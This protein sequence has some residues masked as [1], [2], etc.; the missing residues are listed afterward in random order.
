M[1]ETRLKVVLALLLVVLA[2]LG[3]RAAQLQ[4]V[5]AG[6]WRQKADEA[7]RRSRLTDTIRGTVYDVKGRVL[8]IDAGCFDACI[9][10]RAIVPDP[11]PIWVRNQAAA[12]I[13][14]QYGAAWAGMD[15]ADKR[16]IRTEM[17]QGV[18]R[19]IKLMWEML[20][21]LPGQTPQSIA[22]T[23]AAI[24]NKVEMRKRNVWYRS[25]EK[26]LKEHEK[27]GPAPWYERWVRGEDGDVPQLE[28][29]EVTVGEEISTH[30]VIPAV[31]TDVQNLLAKDLSKYPGLVIR[32]GIHRQYPYGNTG[33]HLMG[34]LARVDRS[35]IDADPFVGHDD[36][37]RYLPSDMIGRGG[38]EGLGE[39]I[40]RGRRG[41]ITRDIAS[42]QIIE[43][44]SP[45]PGG[46]L[47]T[48]IDIE[49]QR[50]I[51]ALFERYSPED[52]W[53][54]AAPGAAV[55]I[56]VRTGEVRAL[57][58][59]PTFDPNTIDDTYAS[60]ARD[61]I[62]QPLLNRATMAQYEPGS[63]VKP[64]IGL[65]AITQGLADIH[66]TVHC[67]GY[68]RLDGRQYG[69]GRCWTTSI[70]GGSTHQQIPWDDPHPT[71][72]LRYEEAIQR[73][74]NIYF[75]TMGHR[76]GVAG[77]SRWLEAFGL[78]HRTGIGIP[79]TDGVVPGDFKLPSYLQHSTA[80]FASIGQGK[81]NATPLQMANVAATI[82][83]DGVWMR[84]RLVG[85]EVDSLLGPIER[86][87]PDVL[88]LGLDPAAVRIA[89]MG[90]DEV[91]N[92]RAGTGYYVKRPDLHLAGKTGTAQAPAFY[93]TRRDA[94]GNVMR[95]AQGRVIREALRTST[96]E[97]PNP[98]APWY[99][100]TTRG[101]RAHA[102]FVGYAPAD[103]PRIAFAVLVQYGGSGGRATAP[104]VRG[105][106]DA[107]ITHGYLEGTVSQP[108]Q[109]GHAS[110]AMPAQPGRDATP[111][112][113][114]AGQ[115][116]VEQPGGV[117]PGGIRPGGVRP[118]GMTPGPQA[119]RTGPQETEA[120]GMVEPAAPGEVSVCN[121]TAK[122]C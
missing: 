71:G 13:R 55:V 115:P 105:L 79:E 9:D 112:V 83:R 25:Y 103:N 85:T 93:V 72:N 62:N 57:V 78:G 110:P 1:F 35:D 44:A 102:W 7:M 120:V 47:R 107:A 69:V 30:V 116:A 2:I 64:I 54:F 65:G 50:D 99:R 66:T 16:R 95:D 20:A 28:Q 22:Q 19:D 80:W 51:E 97:N 109:G 49:L 34:R 15:A 100:T 111:R 14:E 70:N 27:S 82:A 33:S 10:Y 90:M 26:A 113:R 92:T 74:C 119:P 68:L 106:V 56:D 29:F 8:A 32:P 61:D 76:M 91:V 121:A 53:S 41:R 89:K 37:R 73:S 87:R 6:D 24:I 104:V 18:L 17:F 63:T 45:H 11:D 38:F 84:P 101:D 21:T 46:D 58:S 48:T 114:Q 88:D 118:G 39:R 75:E 59:Y 108:V 77:V 67:D 117:Q 40:L 42:D 52:G 4:I 86:E 98:V 60:L 94:A 96:R 122:A 23:R 36:L 3:L 5:Q 81:V 12:R 31:S 43:D